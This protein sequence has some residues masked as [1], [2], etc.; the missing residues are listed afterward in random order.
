MI[1]QITG[2]ADRLTG[3]MPRAVRSVP[4]DRTRLAAAEI[5]R[6]AAVD[7]RSVHVAAEI[8]DRLFCVLKRQL[9]GMTLEWRED[10]AGADHAQLHELNARI[11]ECAA[12]LD[13][14]HAALGPDIARMSQN[15]RELRLTRA[16]AGGADAG[17]CRP[18]RIKPV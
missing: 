9:L 5:V 4:V 12:A 1:E 11:F 13:H 16:A 14:I 2:S 3:R 6:W 7:D 10:P 17:A 18:L 15:E 8:F